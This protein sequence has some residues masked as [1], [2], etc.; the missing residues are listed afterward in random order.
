[1]L[2]LTF[3]E[4]LRQLFPPFAGTFQLSR[5]LQQGYQ[6]RKRQQNQGHQQQLDRDNQVR[7]NSLQ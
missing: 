4:E 5:L 2:P 3:T 7:R 6:Q 1:M